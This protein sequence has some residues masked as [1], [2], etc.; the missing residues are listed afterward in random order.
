MIEVSALVVSS[1]A[2]HT[3]LPGYA[4][5]ERQQV[6]LLDCNKFLNSVQSAMRNN[7]WR[8]GLARIAWQDKEMCLTWASL[9]W[10]DK[11][12][13]GGSRLVCLGY[14][15]GRPEPRVPDWDPFMT[16]GETLT[17]S[18]PRRQ[19]V[20]SFLTEL[21]IYVRSNWAMRKNLR[22][23]CLSVPSAL[24]KPSRLTPCPS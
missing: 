9:A 16:P 17:E 4:M 18:G 20:I 21:I 19:K 6:R 14:L 10:I 23:L 22:T 24:K 5:L 13:L 12:F 7:P 15:I 3:I 11:Y 1:G 8:M 2:Y